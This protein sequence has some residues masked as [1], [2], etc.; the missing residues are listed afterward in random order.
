MVTTS[1]PLSPSPSKE[2]GE[3]NKKRANA[4]LNSQRG[5]REEKDGI[6]A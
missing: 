2:R 4:L 1:P 3:Y 6:L 5:K